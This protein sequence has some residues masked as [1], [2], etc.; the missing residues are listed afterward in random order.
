[1]ATYDKGDKIRLTVTFK[2]LAEVVT[3]PT[4]VYLRVRTPS[5]TQSTHQ[6][7]VDGNVVKTSTGIYYYDLQ[8]SESGT[9]RYK[10]EGTGAL[11]VSEEGR[12][13]VRKSLI[14]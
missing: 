2:N 6:Y 5:G 11:Q 8:I 3:D 14:Q 9:Y 4:N 1:M 13:S 10:W 12:L 7:G